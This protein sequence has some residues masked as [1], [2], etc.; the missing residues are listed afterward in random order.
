MSKHILVRIAG[1]ERWPTVEIHENTTAGQVLELAGC[2]ACYVL[3]LSNG[4]PPIE[5]HRCVYDYVRDGERVIASPQPDV[6]NLN[7]QV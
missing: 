6:T 1:M 5:Q 2:P 3:L 4:E 7:Q